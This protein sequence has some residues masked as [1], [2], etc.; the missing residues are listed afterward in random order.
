MSEKYALKI[1]HH[2]KITQKDKKK[3]TIFTIEGFFLVIFFD[4]I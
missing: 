3:S 1:T 2:K 4:V